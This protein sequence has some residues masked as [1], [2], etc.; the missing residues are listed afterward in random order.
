[1]DAYDPLV[2]SIYDA[3]HEPE[4]WNDVLRQIGTMIGADA[5]AMVRHGEHVD[6]FAFGGE[7]VSAR[8]DRLYTEHFGLIDP[9]TALMR[10]SPV[11]QVL[12]CQDHFDARTADRHEFFQD[13]MRPEG[14]R[15]TAGSTVLRTDR[16]D[17]TTAIMRGPE[18][19]TFTPEEH[20]L[21]QRLMWHVQ[22][23]LAHTDRLLRLR[24]QAQGNCAALNHLPCAVMVLDAQGRVRH[25]NLQA[26]AML[27]KERP[28]RTQQQTLTGATPTDSRTLSQALERCIATGQPQSLLIGASE[29]RHSAEDGK[30][31]VT[32]SRVPPRL[33]VPGFT[34]ALFH[35]LVAP[36]THRRVATV[37]QLMQVFGLTPA[38]ARLAR[39]IAHS[40][41]LTGYCEQSGIK[42]TT[43]KTQLRAALDKTG[44]HNQAELLRIVLAIPAHRVQK[45]PTIHRH[46]QPRIHI[47]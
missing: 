1:M 32:F 29:G 10:R 39:A 15:W 35:C 30:H 18:R 23:S 34:P 26:E 37:E 8:A 33:G 38:E 24:E 22:K 31:C 47:R 43:A 14:L 36:L 28:V 46:D 5:W 25:A 3:S 16:H 20:A 4:R 17:Y 19:G 11:G 27:A 13:F 44:T 2:S 12:L 41:S 6:A 40:E 9:R 42:I 45:A 7:R 21:L